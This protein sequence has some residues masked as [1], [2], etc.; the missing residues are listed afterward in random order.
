MGVSPAV[1]WWTSEPPHGSPQG[2]A[3]RRLRTSADLPGTPQPKLPDTV[4][5]TRANRR[6]VLASVLAATLAR[7]RRVLASSA[8]QGAVA[9]L[10]INLGTEPG[11]LD[12]ARV[13]FTHEIEVVM[14]VFRNL[15][16][17]DAAGNLVPDQAADLPA[18]TDGGTRL[19]FTLQPD[20]TY[21]DGAPL[22]AHDFEYAWKRHL[23]PAVASPYAFA[24]YAIGGAE[25]YNHA[26]PQ[27]TS[28][29][30]L[31]ALRDAVAA[32]ALDDVTLEF[33]L[34]AAAPWFLYVLA[35]WCGVP[36]RRDLVAS[37][38]GGD[39]SGDGWAAPPTY[40]GNGPYVLTAW[41]RQRRLRLVAN[42]RFSGGAPPVANVELALIDDPAAEFAAYVN[43]ELDVAGLAAEHRARVEADPTLRS[44]LQAFPGTCTTY[45]V[46]STVTP[47]LNDPRVR[48]ALA[49]G[50]DRAAYVRDALGG[51]GRPAG[52]F[53]PPGLPGHFTSQLE[54]EL[55]PPDVLAQGFDPPAAQQ[56]LAQAGYP[57]ANG[58]PRL[59][60][61]HRADATS[62]ARADAIRAIYG[63][64][65][66]I[67]VALESVDPAELEARRAAPDRFPMMV[68]SVWCQDYPDPQDWYSAV[69]R[70]ANAVDQNG[71]RS[72]D[73]DRLVTDADAEQN[74]SIRRELYRRA[75]EVLLAETPVVFM[76]WSLVWRLV[77]SRVQGL[78][79]DPAEHFVGEHS[80][81]GV[82][83]SS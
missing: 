12:P 34:T 7:Q 31:Q 75:A 58:L 83:L 36:V 3:L 77:S 69:F 19:T 9:P 79:P 20:L 24:G 5:M 49:L 30:Q 52:Q 43:G 44:Q 25:A 66:G 41:E 28:P 81:Y 78:L 71:W 56:L 40:V 50:F 11:T 60:L 48:Q 73:F 57:G 1:R 32:R 70:S 16:Q 15:L 54:P 10:R 80:L 82:T 51:R 53:I 13:S 76:H 23:D 8:R 63:R 21:S 62:K 72:P 33:R 45:L 67:D 38:T 18:V 65:L 29:D 47:P 26:D 14:R 39:A 2:A 46:L 59:T 4:V 68:D 6:G 35:T 27:Q 55:G 74:P 64:T 61:Q 17:L 22:T 42:P 37:A